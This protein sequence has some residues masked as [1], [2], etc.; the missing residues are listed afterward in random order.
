MEAADEIGLAVIAT[1]FTLIAVFL[2]TAFMSGVAG[3]ILR[4]SSAGRR[5]SRCFFS[6]RRRAHADADDGRLRAAAAEAHARRGSLDRDLPAAGCAGACAIACSRSGRRADLLLRLARAG[7]VAADRL[8]P[9]RRP[10]ADAGADR[11]AARRHVRADRRDRRSGA[12]DRRQEP[13]READ[14]H[15]RRRR[16]DGRRSVHGRRRG[17]GAQGNADAQSHAARRSTR[18][19]QAGG[20]A[21]AARCAGRRSRRAN[22]CRL[23]RLEREIHARPR[24]RGRHRAR[25]RGP[26]RR[27]GTAHVA[28]H[29]QRHL[30][31]EPGPPRADRAAR[32]G[33]RRR[34]RRHGDG[35][36]RDAARGHRGRLRPEPGQAQ[37]AAAPGA[38][39]RQAAGRG[40]HRPRPDLAP[41][42]AGR[43]RAG[44]AR[45]RRRRWR[46]TAARRRSTATTA[47]ATSTST[48]S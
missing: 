25:R 15:H 5:R 39:R 41:R 9:A 11:A 12:A 10:F 31:V 24:R 30:V 26:P 7:A 34:P 36:R 2:P 37:P 42:G 28:R 19:P 35:D 48:S 21:A 46:S 47:C 6:L 13:V 23:R 22:Q 4:R 8:H 40:A 33:A 14:L 45:Q 1:T 18:R 20:R 17:R 29:R 38:D 27:A 32:L 44:D 3:Q 43:A 16:L